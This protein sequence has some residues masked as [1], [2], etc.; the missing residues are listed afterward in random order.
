MT[1]P[2][3][4]RRAASQR[5]AAPK[6]A[7]EPELGTEPKRP[8]YLPFV[9]LVLLA[10][11]WGYNWVMMKVGLRDCDPFTFAVIRNF[12][13]ALAL[14]AVVAIRGGSLRPKI[15]WWTAL[16]GVFQTSLFA[17]PVWA[18]YLGSAGRASVLT[19][20]MPFWLLMMA[21]PILGERIRGLQWVAV[22]LAL[23]GLV[24][25]LGPWNLRNV[26]ASLLALGGGLAWAIGSL[27]FKLV[28][29]RHQIE[30]LPFTAWQALLGTLP[31]VVVAVLVDK[32]GPTWTGSL[33]G[34]LV[35][36]VI[37]GSAVAWLLW[38]YILQNLPAGVAGI[39]SLAVPVVGVLAAWLQLG[40]RPLP[41]E[42]VGMGLIVLALAVLTA[43]ELRNSRRSGGAPPP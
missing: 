39:S 25:I 23:A 21:W 8:A 18:I 31:L 26:W 41:L 30:L 16:F 17:L 27:L 12:L 2:E 36:N 38:M 24:F 4:K 5:P 42:A 32:E 20:T 6:L 11:C 10:F 22:A 40:E 19:Y 1:S 13:G 35:Y 33:I 3:P 28:R 14:I 29:K 34:A 7:T 37:P 43:R 9:A 15:F